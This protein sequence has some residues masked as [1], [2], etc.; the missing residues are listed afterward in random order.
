VVGRLDDVHGSIRQAN[1]FTDGFSCGRDVEADAS[2]HHDLIAVYPVW[3][4]ED[5]FQA[6]GELRQSFGLNAL[7]ADGEF[8]ASDASNAVLWTQLGTHSVG[9]VEKYL[10]SGVVTECVVDRFETI[11]VDVQHADVRS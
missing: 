11:E 1:G 2:A 5:G 3:L 9:R 6:Q 10:V 4:G 8:I 7:R